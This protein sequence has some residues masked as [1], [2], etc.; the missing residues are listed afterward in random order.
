MVANPDGRAQNAIGHTHFDVAVEGSCAGRDQS[1]RVV[2]LS[3]FQRDHCGPSHG[4]REFH[5][6]HG[7]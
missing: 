4:Q 6:A 1:G 2:L 7:K 5:E 3:E